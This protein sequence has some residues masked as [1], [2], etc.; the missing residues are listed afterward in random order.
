MS[1]FHGPQPGSKIERGS[2]GTN[3]PKGAQRRMKQVRRE[4]AEERNTKTSPENRR[5]ARLAA[6]S[7]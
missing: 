6:A 2:F 4:E 7:E 3:G 1:R 5:Q